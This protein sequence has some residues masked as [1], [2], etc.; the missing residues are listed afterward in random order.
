MEFLEQLA[1]L[2]TQWVCRKYVR[3]CGNMVVNNMLILKISI[4]N[5]CVALYGIRLSLHET[6][7]PSLS[8]SNAAKTHS[9]C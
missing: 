5:V 9:A 3:R 1:G 7:F 4:K 6:V 2:R 8:H